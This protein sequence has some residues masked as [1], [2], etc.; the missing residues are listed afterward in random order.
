MNTKQKVKVALDCAKQIDEVIQLM[1]DNEL[2]L[3][4]YLTDVHQLS[5]ATQI[6]LLS[7]RIFHLEKMSMNIDIYLHL[8]EDIVPEL[9]EVE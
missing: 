6:D 4:T 2:P 9:K 7:E 5:D 1:K 3:T 8:I